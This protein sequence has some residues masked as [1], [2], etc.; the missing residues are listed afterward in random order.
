MAKLSEKHLL[1]FLL[2]AS[3]FALTFAYISQYVFDYQPC[4]LCLYQRKPFFA[5]IAFT[6]LALLFSKPKYLKKII[7]FLCLTLLAANGAIATYH[8]GVEKKIF[9]GPTTCSSADLNKY[10]NVKDLEL[11]MSQTKAIRCDEPS[12]FLL[13]LS[14]AAWN[15]IFCFGLF[16]FSIF[17]YRKKSTQPRK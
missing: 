3:I 15:L 11:A 4:I 8:V 17:L 1:I 2:I 14:M 12:F 13:G 6:S 7:F 16:L 5:I 9:R 10:D